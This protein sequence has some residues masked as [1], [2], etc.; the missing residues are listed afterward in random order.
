MYIFKNTE[1]NNKKS[2]DYE[3]KSLLYL[4]GMRK[5]SEKVDIVVIDCFNDVTGV[6]ESFD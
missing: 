5:D 1:L 6:N 2:A 3:T 4:F